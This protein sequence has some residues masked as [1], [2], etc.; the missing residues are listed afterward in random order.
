MPV[1]RFVETAYIYFVKGRIHS[2]NRAQRNT[3]ENVLNTRPF[4]VLKNFLMFLSFN[5]Y[6][7]K[8]DR[9]SIPYH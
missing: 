3:L 5:F 6:A 1:Q 9:D 7:E 4:V 2:N 8:I